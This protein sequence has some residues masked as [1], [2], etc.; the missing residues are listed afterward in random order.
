MDNVKI[1]LIIKKVSNRVHWG[2]SMGTQIKNQI[3]IY[4]Y[5][6]INKM[7]LLYTYTQFQDSLIQGSYLRTQNNI[8]KNKNK[9]KTYT[10]SNIQSVARPYLQI[11]LEPELLEI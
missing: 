5:N 11:L 1:L 10:Y 9:R 6:L 4:V 7:K 8:N 3:I 2:Y